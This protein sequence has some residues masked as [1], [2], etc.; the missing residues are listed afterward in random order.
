MVC[1]LCSAQT[2]DKSSKNGSEK[3]V[4]EY[5]KLS[6][7]DSETAGEK[8]ITVSYKN[9]TAT[10]YVSVENKTHKITYLVDSEEYEVVNN[11]VVGFEIVFIDEPVKEGYTFSGWS[12]NY[13]KMPNYDITQDNNASS[14]YSYVTLDVKASNM[15]LTYAL[16]SGR[17][18]KSIEELNDFAFQF[19]YKFEPE[20]GAFQNIEQN[21]YDIYGNVIDNNS[22]TINLPTGDKVTLTKK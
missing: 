13:S 1:R 12:S 17:L 7:F 19:E 6:G 5:C 9:K 10:I 4:T 3:N 15:R 20:T 14:R 8:T 18:T 22:L 2:R 16:S 21:A 11:V